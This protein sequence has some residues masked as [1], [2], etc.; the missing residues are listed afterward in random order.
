MPETDI[1]KAK[2]TDVTSA[3]VSQADVAVEQTYKVDTAELEGAK[4]QKETKYQNTKWSQQLGYY[5]KI[6]ELKEAINIVAMWTVGKGFIS[7]PITEISLGGIK[8]IAIDTFNTI[9]QNMI[10]N[11]HIGG[12]AFAEIILDEEKNIINLKPLDPGTIIIVADRK[13]R[14][15]RY[16]QLSKIKGKTRKFI[17]EEIFHLSRNRIGDEIHGDSMIEAV[18]DTILMFNEALADWKRV[19]HRNIEPLWIIHADTDD[20]TKIAGIKTDW[21][22]V[23]KKGEAWV[24][25]K[26]VVVPELAATAPNATLNPMP[27]IEFLKGKFYEAAGVPELIAGSGKQFTEASAKIKYLAWQQTIEAQQLFIEENCLNQLS[28]EIELE[29]PA[30][31]LNE[32]LSDKPKENTGEIS[33]PNIQQEQAFQPNDTTAE[34]EGNR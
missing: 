26:G 15:I 9:L 25:P 29:F 4:D 14:I 18:E 7:E 11:Y 33:P 12:D 20:T 24:V 16:E 13:G 21:E 10:I 30:S 2:V 1:G 27:W 3:H 22:K 31:L 28:I 32:T 6:P 17:P 19:L 34:M 8:G 23:R 5:K